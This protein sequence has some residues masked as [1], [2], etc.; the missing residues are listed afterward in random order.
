M[1]TSD[2]GS[3]PVVGDDD[4]D[5]VVT[6]VN[7]FKSGLIF[8]GYG[9]A[10]NAPFQGGTLCMTTPVQRTPLQDS[11]GTGINDCSGSLSLRINAPGDPRFDEGDLVRFQGWFRDPASLSTTGLSDAILV[12]IGT[13]AGHL[14]C[15]LWDVDSNGFKKLPGPP[16]PQA[17]QY[18]VTIHNDGPSPIKVFIA[19]EE[20]VTVA[21]HPIAVGEDKSITF[22][23][24][25]RVVIFDDSDDGEGAS[26]THCYS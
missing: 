9:A 18:K 16:P 25:H 11:G 8:F 5:V 23:D 14:Q 26:G 15:G 20:G 17:S 7:S 6:N 22:I 4:Y 3:A 24:G 10:N 19:N 12:A 13:F 2:P 1:T 21:T